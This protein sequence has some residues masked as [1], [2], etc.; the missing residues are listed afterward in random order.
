MALGLR[1]LDKLGYKIGRSGN[2]VIHFE[3]PRAG[4]DG[5]CN[6]FLNSNIDLYDSLRML[7]KKNLINWFIKKDKN[8]FSNIFTICLIAILFFTIGY[9]SGYREN[10]KEIIPLGAVILVKLVLRYCIVVNVITKR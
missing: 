6:P 2:V 5:R 9:W 4:N 7:D 1:W 8:L 3:H 10:S